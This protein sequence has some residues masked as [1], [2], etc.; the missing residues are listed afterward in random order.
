M[1]KVTAHCNLSHSRG[2][3]LFSGNESTRYSAGF[4]GRDGQILARRREAASSSLSGPGVLNILTATPGRD[5]SWERVKSSN[6]TANAE[7]QQMARDVFISY[8][9][10]DKTVA[11]AVC[12]V[13]ESGGI[14]C[15]IAPRNILAGEGYAASLLNALST[16]R[17]L[18][19]VYSGSSNRSPQVLREVERAVSK[20]L[21]I[22]PFRIEDVPMSSAM[23]YF[24]SSQHW[25]DALTP[26]LESHLDRLRE[27]VKVLL[28]RQVQDGSVALPESASASGSR[29]SNESSLE[30]PR[31]EALSQAAPGHA[32]SRGTRWWIVAGVVVAIAVVLSVTLIRSR[33]ASPMSGSA[34][35]NPAAPAAFINVNNQLLNASGGGDTAAVTRLLSQGADVEARNNQGDSPL[36]MAARSKK[37]DAAKLLI[38][39]G[40]N[41]EDKDNQGDTPL[42]AACTVGSPELAQLLV[43]KGADINARDEIGA[44]PLMYAS[45]AGNTAIIELLLAKGANINSADDN[46]KTPMMYAASAGSVDAVQLM[47]KKNASPAAKD[48][49]GK[50]ALNYAEQWKHPDVVQLLEHRRP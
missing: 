42:I 12:S 4:D 40:A 32:A 27:D 17:I 7:A 30:E 26:P 38:A 24:I 2:A 5:I 23:E 49:N 28:S 41:L 22:V 36:L 29:R 9:S 37:L 19:L 35:T 33:L 18:V 43:D 11:D 14:E 10:N 21:P 8:S 44:T 1:T 46:G 50:T 25:L 3:A 13:L 34:A 16:S 20:G 6:L 45:L 48:H 39:R 31:L 15:W 47:L